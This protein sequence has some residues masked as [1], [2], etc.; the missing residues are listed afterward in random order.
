MSGVREAGPGDAAELV[1]LRRLMFLAMH[2]ADG[3]GPWERHAEESARRLLA[4][5]DRGE[6]LGAFVVE[7]DGSG[8]PP[9]AACAVGTA[10]Q[11]LA[12][13]RH[14]EGRFGF[15]FGVCTDPRYRG[16]GYSRATTEALLDWFGEQ[17][18]TRVDLHAAPDAERLHRSLGFAEH[19]TAFSPD[20]GARRGG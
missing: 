10:E 4:G 11:R 15:V 6:R 8:D 17:G 7:G 18:V 16:R 20:T 13:P 12:A 2:G 9:P 14:P 3:R 1:R 5:T 19:S